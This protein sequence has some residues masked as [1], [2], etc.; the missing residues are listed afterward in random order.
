[1]QRALRADLAAII[2]ALGPQ[3]RR[4]LGLISLLMPVAA[5]AELLLL[6]ATLPFVAALA[7]LPPMFKESHP[8]SDVLEWIGQ[9]GGGTPLQGAVGLF[10]VAAVVATGLRLA[11][12]WSSQHFAY[13]VGHE[14]TLQI[15]RRLLDQPY[16]FHVSHNSSEH[17]A[18][19]ETVDQLVH[20]VIL[21]GIQAASAALI[22]LLVLAGLAQFDATIA[23][24]AAVLV[25]SL[26]GL[27]M[28][29]VRQRM[30]GHARV[31]G[32]AHGKRIRATQE[33]LAGI[34]DV[35]IDQSQ[36]A[37]LD[38]FRDI[39]LAF[40][41]ARWESAFL[42]S[43]PRFLVETIGL[44]GIALLAIILAGRA[45]GLGP[46]LPLLGALAL[47]AQRLL[48]VSHQLY[49]GWVQL[50]SHLAFV[51]QV[52]RL[53]RLPLAASVPSDAEPFGFEQ[54]IRFDRVG[55]RYPG[56]TM[57]ALKGVSLVI[58]KGERIA[59]VGPSGS[60]KSTVADLLMGLIEPTEGSITVD[61]I[62]LSG[63]RM[64]AWRQAIAHVPQSIFLADASIADNIALG[65]RGTAPDLDRARQAAGTAQLARFIESLPDG[66]ATIVGE[67]G[68]RL[69]GGQR[70]RLALARAL[71]KQAPLLVLDEATSALDDATEEAVMKAL[72]GMSA[73]GC[74]IVIIA[75]RQS[76]A[77][78]CDR[79]ICL[80]HGERVRAS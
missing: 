20:S 16:L 75:H 4:Q 29:A 55:F 5:T 62:R 71:Y 8:V 74:T 22:L 17:L 63:E 50:G 3:R 9:Q 1:M 41:R 69:S 13:G 67:R 76:T 39:D 53:L 36:Q 80:D 43:A 51:G 23:L 44:L 30:A 65:A 14:L 45:G 68:L 66:Y 25:T 21:H 70:Q 7:G 58:P 2:H 27:T 32:T 72:D 47:A 42:A 18:M 59:L 24:L 52:A 56:R 33:S 46:A 11:L 54:A 28:F 31:I 78:R 12:A 15:K 10:V 64:E 57:P 37:H 38:H 60:G 35:I 48:P 49:S 19:L 34:R 6:A 61:G 40:A 73:R 79:V 26:Y 77:A